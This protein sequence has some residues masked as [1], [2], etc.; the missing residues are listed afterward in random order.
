MCL[1]PQCGFWWFLHELAPKDPKSDEKIMRYYNI[2]HNFSMPHKKG[3]KQTN[4]SQLVQCVC[5]Y[6]Y[7]YIYISHDRRS[8]P[9]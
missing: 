7:I 1:R 3:L 4:T 5:I 8:E 6:I 2:P 9:Y